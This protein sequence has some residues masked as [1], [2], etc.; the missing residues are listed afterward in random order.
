MIFRRMTW[1]T[2]LALL[3][4]GW[5]ARAAIIQNDVFW[6]DTSGNLLFSQGGGMLKVGKTYYWYGINYGRAAT[7]AADPS[8]QIKAR[9]GFQSVTCYSSTDLAHWKFESTALAQDQVG[10]GWFGRLGVVYNAQSG[11]YVL[12]AQGGSP[13]GI[14][15]EYFATSNSPTG[16][17]I[18]DNVQSNIPFIANGG[19]GDQTTFQ[20][21]DGKAY[22]IC[23]N[24]SGRS[25]L[26]VAPL[27][28]SDFLAIQ[29]ATEI[30][31]G[32][33]REGNCM[34][35]YKGRYYFCS[36]DLHG[37][38]ASPTHVIS[39]T[40]ILGPYGPEVLMRNT[41]LDFSH[42]TQTGFFVTVNGANQ[43]TIIY[44]GDRWSDFGGNGIGYN[45]WCPL[46]FDGT[47]LV[48]HS[49]SQWDLNASTGEW[50]VG[51][52]NNYVL[53]PSFEADRVLQRTLAG[54]S[55][56]TNIQGGDPNGNLKGAGHSGNFCMQQSYPTDYTASMS[57]D[58]P[59]LP[60]S[61]Y[62]L[63]AWVKSSGG[64]NS[65]VIAAKN[66]GGTDLTYSI[67]KPIANWTQVSIPG[68]KVTN[69]K[70][71]VAIISD[72]KANNW[73]QVDD[74]SL[75]DSRYAGQSD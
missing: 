9:A 41:D 70:C 2:V 25:H 49:F 50:R 31:Q 65:A 4:W 16:P 26:Y 32:P 55:N 42:V 29:S 17:F 57:Q 64:Q 69:G 48:F 19:T 73:V 63:T 15:G 8:S 35:K 74:V 45:Q 11:K 53:N 22:V 10:R 27:R 37:W 62:T 59:G 33:G 30:S 36:S 28:D 7:Y 18:F 75:I 47:T 20:D 14:H 66:F 52:G 58:I 71:E 23:C 61:T 12:V 72:A 3:V 24:K 56:T 68:V 40:H 60:N 39:A 44:A 46:S 13:Q 21:D 34:F 43:T 51:P 54:W 67:A 1:I 6:K 38:N 5:A